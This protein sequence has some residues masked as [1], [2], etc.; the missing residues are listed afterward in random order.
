L[1]LVV[2]G[3]V[4]E[5]IDGAVEIAVLEVQLADATLD[6]LATLHRE[7]RHGSHP[8]RFSKTILRRGSFG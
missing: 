3:V 4:F 6:F 7:G 8:P 5:G 1:E 2:E